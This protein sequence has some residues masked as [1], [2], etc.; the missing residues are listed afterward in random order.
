M[1]KG[2]AAPAATAVAIALL[3]Q[4]SLAILYFLLTFTSC[5][6]P[7]NISHANPVENISS[8]LALSRIIKCK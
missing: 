3:L 4:R 6:Y 8:L 2:C 1:D 7:Y 5:E